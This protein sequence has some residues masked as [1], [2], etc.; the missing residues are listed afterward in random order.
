MRR[1]V[2]AIEREDFNPASLYMKNGNAQNK[3][4]PYSAVE[5]ARGGK[6]ETA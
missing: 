5:D 1:G 3:Y 2:S 6:R 4:P